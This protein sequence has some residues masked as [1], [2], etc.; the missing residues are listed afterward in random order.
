MEVLG[1]TDLELRSLGDQARAEA[2]PHDMIGLT[3]RA[4]WTSMLAQS[5]PGVDSCRGTASGVGSRHLQEANYPRDQSHWPFPSFRRQP[6]TVLRAR[7]GHPEKAR[8]HHFLTLC[9]GSSQIWR[10]VQVQHPACQ[11]PLYILSPLSWGRS[12]SWKGWASSCTAKS[13]KQVAWPLWC[14]VA[15]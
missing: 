9:P 12:W 8:P 6:H 5:I 7:A 13:F 15:H 11:D 10:W 4:S 1:R 3:G 14:P 2:C